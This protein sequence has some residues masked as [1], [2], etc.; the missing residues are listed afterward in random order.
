MT[1]PTM[2]ATLVEAP[3]RT[4]LP[5]GL[6]SVLTFRDGDTRWDSA[7]VEME[8]LI[9]CGPL[10]GIGHGGFC[11]DP[12]DVTGLPHNFAQS[13]TGL[14]SATPFSV[15]AHHRCSPVGSVPA[16]T[17]AQARLLTFEERAVEHAF[18]TGML[19]NTPNLRAAQPITA[20][21][22]PFKVGVALLEEWAAAEYGS[23]G[24]IHAPRAVPVGDLRL[25]GQTYRTPLGTAVV[26]GAG[27]DG[28]G[29]TGSAALAADT[30]WI[31]ITPAMVG[32]RSEV[33]V[34]EVFDHAV[35]DLV[36]FAQRDY[37]LAYEDCGVAAA[38]VKLGDGI[39]AGAISTPDRTANPYLTA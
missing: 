25:T 29:P 33:S 30:R 3:P 1:V 37:L 12:A 13:E 36:A 4:P 11:A 20:G 9:G 6:F 26:A 7:G 23:Q 34:D 16:R 24:V 15:T 22:V 31:Y 35:N 38:L 28:T 18:W 8:S 10:Q 39:D 19:G 5:Y 32:Y 27:Y 14:V 17:L 21:A 2:P